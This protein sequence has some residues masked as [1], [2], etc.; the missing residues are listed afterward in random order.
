MK[1]FIKFDREYISNYPNSRE[2]KNIQRWLDENAS[3]LPDAN[4]IYS[5][6][7]VLILMYLQKKFKWAQTL[8]IVYIRTV[9]SFLGLFPLCLEQSNI[10]V[11][12]RLPM[13][14]E[15]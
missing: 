7:Q 1:K 6:V 15:L 10:V 4:G 8:C 9:L 2:S 12:S 3:E 14:Q 13:R 11:Q 5:E